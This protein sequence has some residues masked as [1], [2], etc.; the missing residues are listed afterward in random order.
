VVVYDGK[1]IGERYAEGLTKDSRLMGWSMT[2]SIT[3]A[4][5]GI[6]VKKVKL[7]DRKIRARSPNG[8]DDKEE[9]ESR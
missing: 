3:N 4:L 8:A 9:I 2:K 6:L 1:I 5:V 7:D